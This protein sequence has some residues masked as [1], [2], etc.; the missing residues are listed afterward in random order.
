MNNLESLVETLAQTPPRAG[1]NG[2]IV[3]LAL[4]LFVGA[5]AA[6][7]FLLALES[8]PSAAEDH[9]RSGASIVKLTYSI[10]LAAA[11]A[12]LLLQFASPET[13]PGR[14]HFFAMTPVAVMAMV[15]MTELFTSPPSEWM[16]LMF[17]YGVTSCVTS[18]L[19]ATPPIFAGLVWS[20]RRLAPADTR[21]TGAA[22]G[23]MAGAVSAALYAGL[24]G[25]ASMCFVFIWFSFTI[26][27]TIMAGGLLGRIFLRW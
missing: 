18:I 27:A 24:S 22:I 16:N 12:V 8:L 5:A 10:A 26:M 20:F 9:G 4:G 6:A 15:A 13:R 23:A 2:V 7:A 19:L 3:R 14:R 1:R 17:G 11:A 21:L 25:D